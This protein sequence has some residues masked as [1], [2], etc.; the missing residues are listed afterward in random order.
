M[1]ALLPG[2]AAEHC[3]VLGLTLVWWHHASQYTGGYSVPIWK[4]LPF[5]I[6]Q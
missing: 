4:G 1:L 6:I 5:F 2:P 3:I